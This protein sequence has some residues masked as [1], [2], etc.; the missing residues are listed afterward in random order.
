MLDLHEK[1]LPFH[2]FT[3]LRVTFKYGKHYDG[4]ASAEQGA[5]CGRLCVRNVWVW[6]ISDVSSVGFFPFFF[7]LG[8]SAPFLFL[9]MVP[10]LQVHC[11]SPNKGIKGGMLH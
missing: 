9:C 7:F 11:S 5:Y 2:S 3:C 4:P 10:E 8:A 1:C 6:G